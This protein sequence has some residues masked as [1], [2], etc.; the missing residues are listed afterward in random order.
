M[1]VTSAGAVKWCS[2]EMN[3]TPETL[4]RL[5]RVFFQESASSP[6]WFDRFAGLVQEHGVHVV[7]VIS[8]Y[9][10]MFLHENGLAKDNPAVSESVGAPVARLKHFD[11]RVTVVIQATK[12]AA[13]LGQVLDFYGGFGIRPLFVVDDRTS[14][15][16][17]CLLSTRGAASRD[18]RDEYRD[19]ALISSVFA[20]TETHWILRVGD[21][22]LPT[23][24]LL[25]FVDKAAECS[26]DIDWGFSRVH[27]RYDSS[28]DELQ[29]SQFL[30][31]GPFAAADLQWRLTA[32]APG[33][34]ERRSASSDAVLLNFDWVVRSFAERVERLRAHES[35]DRVA[36]L[37]PLHLHEAIPENWHMFVPLRS[38]KYREFARG[39]ARET[40]HEG[41]GFEALSAD[42]ATLRD[43]LVAAASR[44]FA[45]GDVASGTAAL[46]ELRWATIDDE[47]LAKTD[48]YLEQI[49]AGRRIV[50]TCDPRR[51]PAQDE[52]VIVYGNYPH[53]FE[54]VVVNNPMKRHLATFGELKYHEVE[55]D[56]R[57]D[58]IGQIYI[59][60]ADDRPDRYDA[61]LRELASARAPIHRITRVSAAMDRTTGLPDVDG[62]IGCLRSHIESLRAAKAGGFDHVLVLEDDF[63]F[64]TDLDAH[65]NDLQLFLRRRYDY[66]ICLLATSKYGRI[67]PKDD[68][69]CVTMQPCTNTGGYLVSRTGLEQLLPVQEFALGR[70]AETHDV[71]TFA[72]DRY[73]SVLQ[74]SGQF[75]VF[76]RKFGFQTS[77]FSDIEQRITRYLD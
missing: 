52:V 74:T 6:E 40:R 77:S 53:V 4:R 26:E 32:R 19:S 45:R 73:W 5:H 29:Y 16:T 63:C 61:V 65:M 24:A 31:Y 67:V 35:Q 43:E 48:L 10:A 59:I 36:S 21:D 7:D 20:S 41:E 49:A 54:N 28:G 62:P 44:H 11:S 55:Y 3:L 75:L 25:N 69:V 76:R 58:G 46:R 56:R 23:P 68:L 17:R 66:L 42:P 1:S 8:Y 57:W 37:L 14:D 18:L 12:S 70:L 13:W 27:C 33:P 9:H 51:V 72:A 39:I 64:T 71:T 22:E 2:L 60:N 30:P 34:K 15:E 47:T 38:E 50:A